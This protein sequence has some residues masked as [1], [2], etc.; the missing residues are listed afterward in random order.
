METP[1]DRLVALPS[2]VCVSLVSGSS[3]PERL[4]L[5][6]AL[7]CYVRF[8]NKALS[9]FGSASA[10]RGAEQQLPRADSVQSNVERTENSVIEVCPRPFA[11]LPLLQ[12]S[13]EGHGC[14]ACLSP[15]R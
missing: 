2:G 3:L 9:R 10:V 5:A 1:E 7:P 4:A 14:R 15:R 8:R 6:T 12:H 13:F 11:A